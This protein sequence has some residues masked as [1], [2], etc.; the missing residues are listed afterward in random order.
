MD[1][2]K[3][4]LS[5]VI[6]AHNEEQSI[7][8]CLR[9]VLT[10]DEM[11]NHYEV[12][13]VNNASTDTTAEIVLNEFPEVKLIAE[14]RKGLA[15]AYNRGAK[16]ATGNIVQFVDAD[17]LI[18][19][20]HLRRVLYEFRNDPKLIAVSG[21]YVY[22]AGGFFCEQFIRAMYLL[23]AMPLGFILNR[24]LKRR[25]IASGNLAVNRGAFYKVK[26]FNEKLFYG[27]EPDLASKLDK[28]G[29]V[30]FKYSLSV[31]SSARR[32]KK[33]GAVVVVAKHLLVY[34]APSV[35]GTQFTKA[36]VDIR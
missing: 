31:K 8:S 34:L 10:Q 6:P 4:T 26:G 1:V 19:R 22:D 17:N 14:P 35:F 11:A 15:I 36:T 9:S 21:P 33:E 28:L 18:P 2:S 25:L 27:L 5:V 29:N 23:V 13:V 3:L 20:D 7:R 30:K 32:M 16:E 24:L 12:I